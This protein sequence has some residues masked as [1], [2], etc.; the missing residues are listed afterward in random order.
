[1]KPIPIKPQKRYVRNIIDTW[2]EA[3]A[4]ELV[5]GRNWYPT[6]H[7]LA[8]LIGDGDAV[9]GAGVIAALSAQTSWERNQVLAVRAVSGEHVGT[10]GERL[11]KVQAILDGTHPGA[12]LPMDKKTGQFF[13]CIAD[14]NHRGAVV[15]DRHAFDCAVGKIYGSENRGLSAAG[16]YALIANAYREA[17]DQL[18]ELPLTVQATC[19]LVQL[20]RTAELPHRQARET[21]AA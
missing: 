19:W 15:I 2:N 17:A 1:M 7:S 11:A 14:P 8:V 18:G 4:Q 16:R 6:A 9:K 13:L 20:R 12:V 5:D 21:V 10:T 3:T